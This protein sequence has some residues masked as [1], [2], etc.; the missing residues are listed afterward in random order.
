MTRAAL[1]SV[2]DLV[3]AYIICSRDHSLLAACDDLFGSMFVHPAAQGPFAC[4]RGGMNKALKSGALAVWILSGSVHLAHLYILGRH[5][6]RRWLGDTVDQAL[7]ALALVDLWCE[8]LVRSSLHEVLRNPENRVRLVVDEFLVESLLVEYIQRENRK[9]LT[10]DL[11]QAIF[12]YL[13]LWS[14]RP[15]TQSSSRRLSR[16]VWCRSTRRNFGRCLRRTWSLSSGILRVGRELSEDVLRRRV[17]REILRDFN[18]SNLVPSSES[19]S[20][21]EMVFLCYVSEFCSHAS[22]VQAVFCICFFISGSDL[23]PV[24]ALCLGRCLASPFLCCHQ[25]GR[26][27]SHQRPTFWTWYGRWISESSSRSCF[28]TN[29]F[30]RSFACQ[31][32]IPGCDNFQSSFTAFVASSDSSEVHAASCSSCEY[33]GPPCWLRGPSGILAWIQRCRHSIRAEIVVHQVAIYSAFLE[34]R[35]FHSSAD[36]CVLCARLR[37]NLAPLV[38]SWYLLCAHPGEAHMVAA[39]AGCV[40][41]CTFE[42]RDSQCGNA[43]EE[44]ASARTSSGWGFTVCGCICNSP[45]DESA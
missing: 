27:F 37:G 22:L 19:I 8:P 14:L 21:K 24:V 16:L 36:G 34:R 31:G 45:C 25:H 12:Q 41:L 3:H 35:C 33:A 18:L 32:D 13:W 2:Q 42:G 26:N 20:V 11:Q 5:R 43:H 44:H 7:V 17:L 6:P 28:A 29:R 1:W 9:G 39:T 10:V 4:H 23:F 15:L 38:I 40:L 30:C